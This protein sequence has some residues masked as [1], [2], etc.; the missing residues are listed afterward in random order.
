MSETIPIGNARS[1]KAGGATAA[2][3][4][5]PDAAR[6]LWQRIVAVQAAAK[7]IDKKGRAPQEMGGF[8]FV[9]DTDVSDAARELFSSH[10]IAYTCTTVSA[11]EAE[12]GSTSSGKPIYRAT[13]RIRIKLRNMDEP[14]EVEEIDWWGVGDD[15][16]DKGL[17]KAGT[18]AVK[19]ALMKALLI[20]GDQADPD[21]ADATGGEGRSAR[22]QSG[23]ARPRKVLIEPGCPECGGSLA[24][25]YRAEGKPFVGHAEWKRGVDMCGW[26]PDF[27]T[28]AQWIRDAEAA[29]AATEMMGAPMA[30]D[31]ASPDADGPLTLVELI[32][33]AA[34]RIL[35]FAKLDAD[36]CQTIMSHHGWDGKAKSTDWLR[37]FTETGPLVSLVSDLNSAIRDCPNEIPV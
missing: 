1:R 13:V 4:P 6:N 29:T 22:S 34:R 27:P 17:Q 14:N 2:D 21:A 23:G 24:I 15:M 30:E 32:Q 25:I 19:Y 28:Q 36:A 9:R 10:G 18:S 11:E 8:A 26:K 31:G 5:E 20:G 35:E 7:A 33:T 3:A 16:Q 37:S 12:H